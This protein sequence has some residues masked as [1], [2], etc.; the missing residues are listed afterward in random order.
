MVTPESLVSL[1]VKAFPDFNTF[2][3]HLAR[4]FEADQRGYLK[5]VVSKGGWFRRENTGVWLHV[6]EPKFTNAIFK[7][8]EGPSLTKYFNKILGGKNH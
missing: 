5:W 4:E 1:D 2:L 6:S 3:L 7:W 8:I